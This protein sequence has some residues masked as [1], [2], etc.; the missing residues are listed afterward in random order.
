MLQ[1]ATEWNEA[2]HLIEKVVLTRAPG[3]QIE[4]Q[5]RFA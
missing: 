5:D 1:P 3:D 2:L 4:A